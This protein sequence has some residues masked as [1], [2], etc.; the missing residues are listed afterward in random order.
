MWPLPRRQHDA[1]EIGGRALACEPHE[2]LRAGKASA[3]RHLKRA[4]GRAGADVGQPRA[5]VQILRALGQQLDMRD[6]RTLA[7]R[8]APSRHC[9]AAPSSPTP[10]W[11]SMI[12]TSAP[13]PILISE[14]VVVRPAVAAVRIEDQMDGYGELGAILD[15]D[16]RAVRDEGRVQREHRI[17]GAVRVVLA[18]GGVERE[19]LLHPLVA[20]GAQHRRQGA[21]MIVRSRRLARAHFRRQERAV[22]EQ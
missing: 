21:G 8:R 4:I 9:S 7:D 13:S 5:G 20:R 15:A 1:R 16:D 18:F 3:R 12:V 19:L 10:T 14:R 6:P 2:H 17:A 11:L 22:D